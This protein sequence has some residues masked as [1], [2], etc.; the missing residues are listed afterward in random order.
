MIKFRNVIDNMNTKFINLVD[1]VPNQKVDSLTY[2]AILLLKN[3]ITF[4]TYNMIRE[5]AENFFHINKCINSTPE[6][7]VEKFQLF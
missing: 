1:S 4:F 5:C 3:S 2:E 7:T 6:K